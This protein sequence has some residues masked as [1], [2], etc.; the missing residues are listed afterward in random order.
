MIWKKKGLNIKILLEWSRKHHICTSYKY[1]ALFKI[2]L[3]WFILTHYGN[4][5]G[6]HSWWMSW[7]LTHIQ[8]SIVF[9]HWIYMQAPIV[10]IL[11][12]NSNTR[13]T[14]IG[15]ISHSQQRKFI[16]CSTYPHD[17]D[18]WMWFL[19]VQCLDQTVFQSRQVP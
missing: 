13:I 16:G 7:H 12:C 14:T 6:E 17:L 19:N 4:I 1:Y 8:T 3:E 9:Q 5:C 2:F 15:Y 10:R 18:G 11:K